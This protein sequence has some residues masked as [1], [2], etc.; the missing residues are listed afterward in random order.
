MASVT[1]G[2]LDPKLR[3]LYLKGVSALE[4]RNWGYSISLF[5]AVLKQQPGFL[6]CR[7]QL[8]RAAVENTKGKKSL[9]SESLQAMKLK[10]DVT[11]DPVAA[12]VALEKNVLATDPFNSQGNQLLSEAALNLEM[13]ETAAFAL[14]TLTQSDPENTKFLH[15]LG[16]FQMKNEQFADATETYSKI[17]Q[18]DP[19]DLTA[20]KNEKDATARQ[21][22][23]SQGWSEDANLRDLLKDKEGATALEQKERSGLT[24]DQLLERASMLGAQYAEDNENLQV[25]KELAAT[26]ERLED[27]PTALSYFEWA[28]HLS[29]SDPALEK[30]VAELREIVGERQIA[31]L[32]RFIEEN[33]DH[34]EVEQKKEELREYTAQRMGVLIEEAKSRVDRNPTDM[35]LRYDYGRRLFEAEMYRETIPQLQ[36]ATRSPNLRIKTILM[37][38]KCY[39]KMNMDDLAADQ[40]QTAA[41]E[42]PTLDD[43][44]KDVLYTLALLF[45]KM[46]KSDEYL[47]CLKEIY[48][49]D[50]SY[51]DVAERVEKSYGG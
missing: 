30:K 49:A 45:E 3:Q 5:Q 34:P 28:H 50:Y 24:H 13:A 40:L 32:K 51:R 9:G 6:E 43:T 35:Q 48:A 33:P 20:I 31:S 16:E 11:K 37:L 10:S 2:D 36:Q 46:G 38:G 7:K 42:I 44:K 39:E 26:Y 1:E 19:S 14:N 22:M 12:M 15:A 21:S 27:Y 18:L 8:R 25:T 47:E 41:S 29:G 23:S 17:R 4:L